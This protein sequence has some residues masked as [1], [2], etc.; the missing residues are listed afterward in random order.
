MNMTVHVSHSPQE[1]FEVKQFPV[2]DW[3]DTDDTPHS[4]AELLNVLEQA[5][6]WVRR[7]GAGPIIV[8]CRSGDTLV[9][10]N[11]LP[12]TTVWLLLVTNLI[13]IFLHFL[14]YVL[15][16]LKSYC[17]TEGYCCSLDREYDVLTDICDDRVI[18]WPRKGERNWSQNLCTVV[19]TH[20]D[21]CT[22]IALT[23][24]DGPSPKMLKIFK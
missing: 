24:W 7:Q 18:W 3:P 8:H 10:L 11:P 15:D 13:S 6:A 20:N 23:K 21:L 19:M 4:T 16:S 12:N 2:R 17:S 22:C 14:T 5:Q 1:K 9:C